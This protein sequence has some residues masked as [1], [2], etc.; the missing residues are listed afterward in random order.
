MFSVNRAL[1]TASGNTEF[2]WS[3]SGSDKLRETLGS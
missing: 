2:R 3:I 1:L